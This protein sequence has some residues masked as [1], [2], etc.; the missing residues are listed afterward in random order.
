ME[1]AEFGNS[2]LYHGDTFDIL[3]TL[4]DGEIDMVASDPPYASETFGKCTEC[5]W[6]KP[7]PLTEFWQLIE[8]KAKPSANIVLFGNMKFAFDLIDSNRKGFRYDLVWAKNNRVGFLNAKKMVMRSH[9]SILLFGKPG[10]MAAATYNPLK[11][12][13]GRPVVKR[14]KTRKVDGVYPPVEAATTVSD[15]TLYPHSVLAFDHD[16]GGNQPEACLH[17][18]MKPLLLMGYLL[19]LYSNPGD[20]VLDPFAG[21][22]TTLEAAMKL[23]RRFVGIERERRYY[24]IACRRLEEA[25]RKRK[26]RFA[27]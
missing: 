26:A 6:D 19:T 18:T 5:D 1:K 22:G 24:E 25:Y 12:P 14:G 23:G 21:S 2:V 10:Y 8:Y 13:G 20:L 27:G 15:G 9:E 3:P 7:I 4:N 11:I 16:R 17:P